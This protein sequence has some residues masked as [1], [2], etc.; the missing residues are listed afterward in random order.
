MLFATSETRNMP[1]IGLVPARGGSK[2]LP[3]KNTLKINN[4]ALYEHACT[5]GLNAGLDHIFISTDIQEILNSSLPKGVTALHRPELL[6][7]DDTPMRDVVLHAI[8]EAMP[9]ESTVVLLQPTSPLRTSDH[10]SEALEQYENNQPTLLMS[11]CPAESSVLKFGTIDS[12]NQ[13]IAMRDNA[14]CFANR[15][16]LQEVFRPNGAIYVFNSSAF[17]DRGDFDATTIHPYVMTEL[18]SIDID[19]L[20]DFNAC[21]AIL[22]TE[23]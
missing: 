18:E 8:S 13:Y 10:I 7:G 22:E 4:K 14:D 12:H 21:A 9:K 11:V 6:S 15:Q 20:D 5:S 3:N 19:S 2:G 17:K 16:Q 23:N 1:R